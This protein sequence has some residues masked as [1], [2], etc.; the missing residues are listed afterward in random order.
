M[1]QK[2]VFDWIREDLNILLSKGV[3]TV[4][5]RSL[6]EAIERQE[7]SVPQVSQWRALKNAS[8]IAVADRKSAV[9]LEMFKS[10]LEAGRAAVAS[11]L[12]VN[13]GASVAI[14]AFLANVAIKSE[15]VVRAP[16][17]AG[18]LMWFA[19]GVLAAAVASG[20]TY[21]TQLLYSRTDS[22]SAS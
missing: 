9:D 4:H 13:G 22:A 5:T 20:I 2:D 16:A 12:L 8:Q 21:V 10:V 7:Q 11:A 19:S 6:L 17:M 15:A 14:L 3:E 18:A 1:E